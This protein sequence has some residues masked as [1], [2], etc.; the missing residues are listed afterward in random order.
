MAYRETQLR[1][2]RSTEDRRLIRP[3]A[4]RALATSVESP[5]SLAVAVKVLVAEARVM[6]AEVMERAIMSTDGFAFTARC[7]DRAGLVLACAAVEPDVVV[8]DISLFGGD[9]DDAVRAVREVAPL[10]RV[11]MSFPEL[12]A[13]L[14]ARALLA[15][16]DNCVSG[17]VDR[18]QFVEAVRATAAGEC[19]V[20][21]ELACGL[22]RVITRLNGERDGHLS[23]RE[24][25]V[26][27]LAADGLSVLD[28]ARELCVSA[29]TAHTHLSRIYLK[30][31]VHSRIGAIA[32]AMR[33]GILR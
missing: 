12:D 8:L 32:E 14:L 27:R 26:L 16:A 29:N 31:G 20:P 23:P 13:D 7:A 28:I 1:G 11:L 33:A 30:L 4:R 9:V 22:G 25:E 15:G 24:I 10:A 5:G 6:A 2:S 19:G 21:A 3:R 17:S 18:D